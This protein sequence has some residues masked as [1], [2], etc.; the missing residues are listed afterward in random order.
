V[1][2][3]PSAEAFSEPPSDWLKRRNQ[4]H[5]ISQLNRSSE[6]LHCQNFEMTPK[7]TQ[8]IAGEWKLPI[9]ISLKR[10]VCEPSQSVKWIG[11]QR[12]HRYDD[13]AGLKNPAK[14]YESDVDVGEMVENR[15]RVDNIEMAVRPIV[16]Q[17]VHGFRSGVHQAMC[18]QR[19]VELADRMIRKIH[20]DVLGSL[21]RHRKR[22]AVSGKAPEVEDACTGEIAEPHTMQVQEFAVHTRCG[23]EALNA[24]A[25]AG[26]DTSWSIGGS[27][28]RSKTKG[29]RL[30]P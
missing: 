23:T 15:V 13:A 1:P 22:K 3:V 7:P 8:G 26:P 21:G 12:I 30:K 9:P 4:K 14:L 25:E 29:Y 10:S 24:A 20:S 18:L 28:V 5:R 11:G 19:I 27:L 6:P 2:E 16:F 17:K